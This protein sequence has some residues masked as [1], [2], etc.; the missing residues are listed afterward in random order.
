VDG[1]DYVLEI[2]FKSDPHAW[3]APNTTPNTTS[4]TGILAQAKLQLDSRD[5]GI[6]LPMNETGDYSFRPPSS[7]RDWII[8][9]VSCLCLFF[10]PL[11]RRKDCVHFHF[12]DA[13]VSFPRT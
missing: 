2:S 8:N 10:S 12:A 4:P 6:F 3:L 1:A 7:D 11:L 9:Q 13:S 5:F